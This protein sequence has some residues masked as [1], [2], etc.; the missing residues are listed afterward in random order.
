MQLMVT[1]KSQSL[2]LPERQPVAIVQQAGWA[3]SRSGP[4]RKISPHWDWIPGPSSPQPV[5][6]YRQSCRGPYLLCGVNTPRM[7]MELPGCS[8]TS[9]HI[10]VAGN[11]PKKDY[12]M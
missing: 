11:Q 6:L 9:T 10:S 1:T 2:Y 4:V 5:A 7:T 8:E 12:E 3:Q